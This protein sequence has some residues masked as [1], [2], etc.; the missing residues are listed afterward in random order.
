[1]IIRTS[2]DDL[3]F[4]NFASQGRLALRADPVRDYQGMAG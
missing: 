2:P 1:M 4:I 3:F